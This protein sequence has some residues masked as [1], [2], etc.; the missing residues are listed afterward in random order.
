MELT[1]L[2]VVYVNETNN[3]NMKSFIYNSIK[4]LIKYNSAPLGAMLMFHRIDNLNSNGLW[5]N[6]LLK[7]SP[8]NIVYE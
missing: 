3:L 6:E 7:I 2:E 1:L 4:R 8:E 5:A